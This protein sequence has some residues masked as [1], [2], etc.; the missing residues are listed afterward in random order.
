MPHIDTLSLAIW[1]E[2]QCILTDLFG[3]L[4]CEVFAMIINK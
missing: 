3:C 2:V 4:L 1:V